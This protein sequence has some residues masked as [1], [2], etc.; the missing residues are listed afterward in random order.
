MVTPPV[1]RHHE[2]VMGT[3]VTMDVFAQVD[4]DV[5]GIHRRIELACKVLHLADEVF[6][7]WKPESPMSRLRRGAISCHEV[8]REVTEVLE[9]CDQA[10]RLSRGWFDPWSM[11]GGVDPTGYVK[12]WAAQRAL[13]LLLGPGAHG[14]IVNAAGDIASFGAQAD[15]NAFRIGIV[16]PLQP[17]RLACVV[18]L[19]ANIAT[20]GTCERGAHL[21][22]PHSGSPTARVASA[23]V[24]GPDLGLADALATALGV[25]GEEGL[26]FVEVVDD[27]EALTIAFDGTKKWTSGFP[28]APSKTSSEAG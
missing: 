5:V 4:A 13:G 19:S 22:D 28:F 16:D 27:Y 21:I 26:S 3:I 7:T 6:S 20:S 12:G 25:A 1:I 17:A 23:S 14:A 2:E 8:P 15:G 9:G 18:N 10:R 11:P 24:C